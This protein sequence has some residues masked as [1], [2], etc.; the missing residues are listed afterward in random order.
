[1]AE[2]VRGPGNEGPSWARA[3]RGKKTRQY[4]DSFKSAFLGPDFDPMTIPDPASQNFHVDDLS[5]PK[6]VAPAAVENRRMFLDVIDRYYR[7]AVKSAEHSKMD[8]FR[9]KAL[10][11]ILTPGVQDAFDLSKESD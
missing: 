10:E 2:K 8:A 11:M 9:Q 6:S 5:L 7:G 1:V 4:M 3:A